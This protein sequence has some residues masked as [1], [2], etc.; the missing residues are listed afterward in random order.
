MAAGPPGDRPVARAPDAGAPSRVFRTVAGPLL[1]Y[2]ALI[3][4]GAAVLL[5]GILDA[6]GL[7]EVVGTGLLVAGIAIEVAVLVYAARLTR[8]AAARGYFERPAA[9]RREYL[10]LRCALRSRDPGP[11][12]PR[13]GG[14][15][16]PVAPS[17]R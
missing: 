3:L 4:G 15:R 8:Q 2:H 6:R 14:S 11:V 17:G 13:C 1:L 10:C 9:D 5:L 7:W 16:V 12:C